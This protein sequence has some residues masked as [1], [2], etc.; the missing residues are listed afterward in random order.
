[1]SWL[2]DEM[3]WGYASEGEWIGTDS[4]CDHKWEEKEQFQVDTYFQCN[5]CK[6]TKSFQEVTTKDVVVKRLT[7]H[8]IK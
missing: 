3:F 7:T 2:K 6:A 8:L 1:M 4:V 5:K